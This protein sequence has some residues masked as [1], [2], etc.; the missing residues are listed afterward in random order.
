LENGLV[1]SPCHSL[2]ACAIRTT[3][4]RKTN[5]KYSTG[6]NFHLGDKYPGKHD[7]HMGCAWDNLRYFR[8]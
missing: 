3:P 2:P 6:G 5:R 1:I 7:L 4:I 8:E